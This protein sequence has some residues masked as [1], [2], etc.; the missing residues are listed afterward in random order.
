MAFCRSI[1]TTRVR[2][3]RRS[4]STFP[5]S[6]LSLR[7]LTILL[8]RRRTSDD[9]FADLMDKILVLNP[10]KRLTAVEALDH[11][12]F[13]ED[14]FPTDPALFV[15]FSL[16]LPPPSSS[17]SAYRLPTHR[18]PVYEASHEMDRKGPDGQ[19]LRHHL[20]QPLPVALVPWPAGQQRPVPSAAPH[21]HPPPSAY[22]GPP[23]PM[24]HPGH[25]QGYPPP[26]PP[27]HQGGYGQ[28]PPAYGRQH[29]QPMMGQS[30]AAQGM[31]AQVS[32]GGYGFPSHPGGGQRGGPP[33]QT[34]GKVNLLDRL[35]KR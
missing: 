10:K 30:F 4:S 23:P 3:V 18:M 13:W 19:P 32:R 5:R 2:Q 25:H 28:A 26:P 7:K 34:T 20:P 17:T 27:P 6:L 16:L 24:H 33:P 21:Y 12:W 22:N 1:G 29:Q 8:L 15:L 35:K 31:S 11:P 9:L 14:P